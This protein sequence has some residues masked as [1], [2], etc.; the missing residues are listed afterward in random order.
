MNGNCDF[1][2]LRTLARHADGRTAETSDC[3]SIWQAITEHRLQILDTFSSGPRSCLVLGHRA[4]AS[5]ALKG[6]NLEILERMLL[7][8][9]R[10][11][12]SM[13]IGVSTSTLAQ[14]LKNALSNMGLS[15]SPARVP[16]LLVLFVH[17]ARGIAPAHRIAI[18]GFEQDGR[19]Y[20]VI[21]SLLDNPMMHKLTPAER[22]V[23]RLRLSG[24]SYADIASERRTSCRTVANQIAAA[25][26]RLGVSGR[27]DLL[28]L[29][30]SCPS[31]NDSQFSPQR[32]LAGYPSG[33]VGGEAEHG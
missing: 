14:I 33:V 18:A 4:A 16:P 27:L 24:R 17:A 25:S 21:S 31:A 9:S 30:A 13:E 20:V 29:I 10:K 19:A 28:H 12:V 5:G 11:V 6:R 1:S 7:G 32:S 15:C 22:E 8:N 3:R 2:G 23:I 26:H